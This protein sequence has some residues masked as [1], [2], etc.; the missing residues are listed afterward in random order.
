MAART[1]L[2]LSSLALA[3]VVL[4]SSAA[5][6]PAPAPA[7]ARGLAET[8]A[9]LEARVA[10]LE[11]Q[12]KT[13]SQA[14]AEISSRLAAISQEL[15]R[16]SNQAGA[17]P[18]L[19]ERVD[20]AG[21]RLDALERELETLRTQIAG[22]EQPSVGGGGAGRFERGF[23]VVD[24]D[25][26]LVARGYLQT[27]WIFRLP[28]ELDTITENT[29]RVRRARLGAAGRLGSI[30]ERELRYAIL[31]DM[32]KS[33]S[34]LDYSL[35]LDVLPALAVRV[36][37]AKVPHTR[38]F[39]TSS[40][41][42]LFPERPRAVDTLRYD[43]DIGIWATGP[44]LGDRISYTAGVSNGGGPNQLNDN[45]DLLAV[46]RADAAV[47]GERFGLAFSD[48]SHVEVPTLMVGASVI[49]DLVRLP[50]EVAGIP[51]GNRDV[52][53]DQVF[54]NVRVIAAAADAV[55]RYRGLE[56]YAEGLLRHERWGTI[57]EHSDNSDVALQIDPDSSGG[58]TYLGAVGQASYAVWPDTVVVGARAGYS[59]QALLGVGGQERARVPPGDRLLEI[60]AVGQLYYN[61]S[62]FLALQYSFT[63]FDLSGAEDPDLDMEHRVLVQSQ[64]RF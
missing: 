43:R 49:H 40:R 45:I 30:W 11:A 37:Q 58:K 9:D 57:L 10:R 44:L 62:P 41:S 46:A 50:T 1:V 54:D 5:A 25:Y 18:V 24:G 12:D 19:I 61:G 35:E 8:V 21:L 51:L 64:L 29:F 56:L 38:S 15:E 17:P 52:D 63:N 31:M 3:L 7:P 47:L 2:A 60:D 33:P 16:L 4:A 28:G 14:I 48:L 55:F 23:V 32:S 26:S 6:Q 22:L 34:L 36:G 20:A 27:Q 39:M 42:L 59:Q 53:N 13:N